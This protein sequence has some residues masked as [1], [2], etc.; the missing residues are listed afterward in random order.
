VAIG[1]RQNVAQP[2]RLLPQRSR[3]TRQRRKIVIRDG[4]AAQV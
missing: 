2:V 1:G 3:K 4:Y